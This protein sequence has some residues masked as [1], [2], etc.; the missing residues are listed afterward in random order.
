MDSPACS[1]ISGC[2]LLGTG[3]LYVN[4]LLQPLQGTGR[5]RSASHEVGRNCQAWA[6]AL[7]HTPMSPQDM[8]ADPTKTHHPKGSH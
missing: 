8:A 4:T 5:S 7:H 1:E 2:T 6:T 3:Y